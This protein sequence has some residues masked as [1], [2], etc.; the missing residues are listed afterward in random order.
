MLHQAFKQAPAASSRPSAPLPSKVPLHRKGVVGRPRLVRPEDLPLPGSASPSDHWPRPSSSSLH[1]HSL[2]HDTAGNLAHLKSRGS[3][4]GSGSQPL[5]GELEPPRDGDNDNGRGLKTSRDAEFGEAVQQQQGLGEGG[6]SRPRRQRS[7]QQP[8]RD[9]DRSDQE[10]E[11][12]EASREGSRQRPVERRRTSEGGSLGGARSAVAGLGRKS[13]GHSNG[14]SLDGAAPPFRSSRPSLD[15]GHDH[16]GSARSFHQKTLAQNVNSQSLNSWPAAFAAAPER[17]DTLLPVG[18][19]HGA[20][21]LHKLGHRQQQQ[22]RQ[23]TTLTNLPAKRPT[24]LSRPAAAARSG[25][26]QP[27]YSNLESVTDSIAAAA[28]AAEAKLEGQEGATTGGGSQQQQDL[29]LSAAEV[30]S[31]EGEGSDGGVLARSRAALK[32]RL[33]GHLEPEADG[34]VSVGGEGE[35][36]RAS[37]LGRQGSALGGLLVASE[38]SDQQPQK[39]TRGSDGGSQSAGGGGSGTADALSVAAAAVAAGG[40]AET[41]VTAAVGSLNR[42]KKAAPSRAAN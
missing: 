6:G 29:P 32:K 35:E 1:S 42:R 23:R 28:A 41:A 4:S 24:T 26:L 10:E 14:T 11:D 27:L 15:P 17:L 9:E 25:S 31:G 7:S 2:T 20:P 22:P 5:L 8:Y 34:D 19:K 39:R 3:L 36:A 16:P 37:Q 12:K 30:H 13:T 33:V 21:V 18:G 40:T 38:P